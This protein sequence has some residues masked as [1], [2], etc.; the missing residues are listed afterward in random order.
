MQPLSYNNWSQRGNGYVAN[1]LEIQ[2]IERKLNEIEERAN[3]DKV[4]NY[5]KTDILDKEKITPHFLRIAKTVSNDSL[6]KIRKDDGTVFPSKTEQEAHIVKFYK[7]LYSLPEVMPEDFTN[8][9]ENF[10][11]PEICQHPVVTNSKLN[12][13][14]KNNL[15]S[16]LNISELDESV[17]KLNLRSAPG[18]DGVSNRFIA[19]F[20]EPLHSYAIKCIDNGRLTDTFRTAIIRLI[21]KK[22]NTTQLKN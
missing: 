4:V 8:C 7:D 21:P 3:A 19:N 14:E 10:L 11:G 13:D 5:L 1:F 15:E 2:E 6:E 12:E 22:G 17:T 9:I 16:P 20:R 18:I